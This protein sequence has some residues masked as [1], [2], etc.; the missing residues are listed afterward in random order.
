[1]ND[2]HIR[3]A[4]SS[5]LSEIWAILQQAIARRR[6]EGSTQ[7]QDGYPNPEV[8]LNDIS[9]RHG[10][11]CIIDDTIAVY[12]AVIQND[13][14]AYDAL[15]G[16]W[17]SHGPFVVLHRVA[18]SDAFLGRGLAERIF[19]WAEDYARAHDIYS[20]KVDTKDDN[21]AM[22]HIVAKL[23]YAYCGVVHFR[24]GSRQA[25]EKILV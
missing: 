15:E 19:R 20:I 17:R 16:Q 1:M 14:P 5:D 18:V 7:W 11:V 22:L 21:K 8:V 23:G 12:V 3:I 25:F 2:S 9:K 6:A 4:T 13:E 10:Y 24:A